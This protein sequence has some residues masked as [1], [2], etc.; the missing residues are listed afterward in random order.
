[1]F[2]LQIRVGQRFNSEL[3]WI[4][5]RICLDGYAVNLNENEHSVVG[6]R[7]VISLYF[8]RGYGGYLSEQQWDYSAC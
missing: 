8:Y 2:G 4:K 6:L 7:I 1:M 5:C 3:V